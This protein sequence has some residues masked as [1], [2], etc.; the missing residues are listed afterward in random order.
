[1]VRHIVS[2]NFR[3]DVPEETRQ[4]VLK[5]LAE[6]F[7][8]LKDKVP[9]VLRVE[10]GMPP[11]DSSNADAALYVELEDEAA[12]EG[13]RTHPDHLAVASIVRAHCQERR[14]TDFLV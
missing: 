1:M 4:E 13:Y 11:M 2:W 7:P 6:E 3:P 8:K 12:L 5:K 10:T 14:C 9:G